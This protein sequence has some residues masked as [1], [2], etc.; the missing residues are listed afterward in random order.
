MGPFRQP[1][2]IAENPVSKDLELKS[3]DGK[4][5]QQQKEDV[6]QRILNQVE[7][8]NTSPKKKRVQKEEVNVPAKK[9]EGW[10]SK[11]TSVKDQLLE[12]REIRTDGTWV[13]CCACKKWRHLYDVKDPSQVPEVWKC[14]M[15]PDK[16]RNSCHAAEEDMEDYAESVRGGLVEVEYGAGSVV[17]AKMDGWPWWPGLVDDDPDTMEFVWTDEG[18]ETGSWY[19]VVFFDRGTV[20]RA[21]IRRENLMSYKKGQP[22][23][24]K[25]VPVAKSLLERRLDAVR[26]AER[27]LDMDLTQ[28]KLNFCFVSKYTGKW[29]KTLP[30]WSKLE[31]EPLAAMKKKKKADTL[32]SSAA[33]GK[34]TRA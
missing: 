32:I 18:K 11:A 1:A 17:W 5:R 30:D 13:E 10:L 33:G 19:H 23:F 3:S 28:R 27:A 16:G 2:P 25:G 6:S 4:V 20:S 8:L 22:A 24:S 14:R 26:E 34:K 15:N 21:W 7:G 31:D 12:L 29:G 9:K